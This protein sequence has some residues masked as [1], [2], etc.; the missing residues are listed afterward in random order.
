M[1]KDVLREEAIFLDV[2][3]DGEVIRG[4]SDGDG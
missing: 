1:V 3:K 4:K 2:V